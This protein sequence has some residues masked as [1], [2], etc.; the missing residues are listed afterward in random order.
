VRLPT[1]Y[2]GHGVWLTSVTFGLGL[3][4]FARIEFGRFEFGIFCLGTTMRRIISAT[5]A[6]HIGWIL[7]QVIQ[8]GFFV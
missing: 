3:F 7:I 8:K 6:N 1:R 2:A 5:T 4:G